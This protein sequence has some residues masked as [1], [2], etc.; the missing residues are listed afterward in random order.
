MMGLRLFVSGRVRCLFVCL[1]VCFDI[2]EE[3]QHTVICMH[4][5][6]YMPITYVFIYLYVPLM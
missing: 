4:L 3:S 1:F 2:S 5:F 6:K